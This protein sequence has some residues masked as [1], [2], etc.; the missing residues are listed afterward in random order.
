[1][2][3]VKDLDCDE[4]YYFIEIA[5]SLILYGIR[6][7]TGT[8]ATHWHSLRR[9]GEKIHTRHESVHQSAESHTQWLVGRTSKWDTWKLYF[10]KWT[11][12]MARWRC[13]LGITNSDRNSWWQSCCSCPDAFS[14]QP[15]LF[16][17]SEGKPFLLQFVRWYCPHLPEK[18]I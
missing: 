3:F 7:S 16:V 8:L 4:G 6:G 18:L 9:R 5:G 14:P 11:W 15:L 12:V 17:P 13:I 2:K 10:T 1:M